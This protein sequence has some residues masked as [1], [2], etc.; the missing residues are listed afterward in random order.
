MPV[1]GCVGQTY[2]TAV[3][4]HSRARVVDCSTIVRS[5]AIQ[6]ASACHLNCRIIRHIHRTAITAGIATHDLT[7]GHVQSAVALQV[8]R[9]AVPGT[10]LGKRRRAADR[11]SGY[12]NRAVGC[13]KDCAAVALCTGGLIVRQ[14]RGSTQFKRRIGFQIHRAAANDSRIAGDRAAGDIDLCMVGFTRAAGCNRA[15]M[16]GVAG[17]LVVGNFT[18]GNRHS[19]LA[20]RIHRAAAGDSLVAG[21]RTC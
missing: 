2:R 4:G 10:G 15:A 8:N 16:A 21:N 9:A 13:G 6:N 18:A 5:G 19:A 14:G 7:R 1:D 11:A 3:I 20:F 17:G 12:R